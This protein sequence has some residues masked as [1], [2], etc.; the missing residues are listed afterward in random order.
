MTKIA[1]LT[2]N[3][4]RGTSSAGKTVG[5]ANRE[6]AL[7]QMRIVQRVI[8]TSSITALSWRTRN[9]CPILL[10]RHCSGVAGIISAASRCVGAMSAKLAR[11]TRPR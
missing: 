1:N 7:F 3:I 6:S 8:S 2:P 4:P 11:T 10:A 5:P 9:P